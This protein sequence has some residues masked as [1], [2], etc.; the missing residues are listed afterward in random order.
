MRTYE[1]TLRLPPPPAKFFFGF[2]TPL[3]LGP[4]STRPISPN[5][6]GFVPGKTD[7]SIWVFPFFRKNGLYG[8]FRFSGPTI[9]GVYPVFEFYK[10]YNL[11]KSKAVIRGGQR[12]TYH[13]FRLVGKE[14]GALLFGENMGEGELEF[15]PRKQPNS[16]KTG[17]S[18]KTGLIFAEDV[19][20]NFTNRR[21]FYAQ[22]VG[23]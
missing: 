4:F 7:Y 12:P 23:E 13:H 16:T 20:G 8:F 3:R 22:R 10:Y 14:K 5:W 6:V 2:V 9:Y 11:L 19:T 15:R 1:N 21:H 17:A 18:L